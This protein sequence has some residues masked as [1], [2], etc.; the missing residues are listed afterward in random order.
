MCPERRKHQ[1]LALGKPVRDSNEDE[2]LHPLERPKANTPRARGH[3]RIRVRLE[4]RKSSNYLQNCSYEDAW[5]VAG[6]QGFE[7]R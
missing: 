6:R 5:K 4:V 1:E 3:I 7:P 2:S